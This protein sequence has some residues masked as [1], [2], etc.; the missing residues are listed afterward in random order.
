MYSDDSN[1]DA[2]MS[3]ILTVIRNCPVH[4]SIKCIM[5]TTGSDRR[6]FLAHL[7]MSLCNHALSVVWCCRGCHWHW[8]HMCT[9]LPVT[10]LIIET[11]YFTNICNY[12]PSIC[13]WNIS[14]CDMYFLNGSHFSKFLYVTFLS[15]WLNLRVFILGSYVSILGLPTEKKLCIYR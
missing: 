5:W 8:H 9:A 6:F 2:T 3:K 1:R 11:L 7:V 4:L 13:T 12:T 15:T 10:A 14:Q